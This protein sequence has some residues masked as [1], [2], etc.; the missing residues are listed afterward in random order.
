MKHQPT[1]VTI[2]TAELTR[3]KRQES[4]LHLEREGFIR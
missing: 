2:D 4:I 1:P 3:K